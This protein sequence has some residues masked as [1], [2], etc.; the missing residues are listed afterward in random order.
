LGNLIMLHKMKL[1]SIAQD[2]YISLYS[3]Y[4]KFSETAKG[5]WISERLVGNP[6]IEEAWDHYDTC[7]T[8]LISGELNDEDALW[9]NIQWGDISKQRITEYV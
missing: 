1:D 8:V 5:K 4:A 2:P 3:A 6:K 9:F 7:W